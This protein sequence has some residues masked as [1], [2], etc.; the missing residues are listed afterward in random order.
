MAPSLDPHAPGRTVRV[1][2]PH[3]EDTDRFGAALAHAITTLR[4]DIAAHGLYLALS[5]DLGAGKTALI[6]AVLRACGI[7]GP[8]RSPTFTLLEPYV[9]SSL[10][11]HHFDFYRFTDPEEFASAGFRELFG[12]GSICAV[13]WP[14]KAAALLPDPDLALALNVAGEGRTLDATAHTDIGEKC[15]AIAMKQWRTA[16][17][18]GS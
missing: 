2:L 13:E 11:F 15:L 9:V 14:E 8:V 4:E 1:N 18:E 12:P 6:R 17:A 10:N 5:G 3:A 7:S 16:G